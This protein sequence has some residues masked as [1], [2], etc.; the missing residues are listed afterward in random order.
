[1]YYV[2]NCS[3]P[4]TSLTEVCTWVNPGTNLGWISPVCGGANGQPYILVICL[5][6]GIIF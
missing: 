6:L 3:N 5:L 2:N 4:S 1:M